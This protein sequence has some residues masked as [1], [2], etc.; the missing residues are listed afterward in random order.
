MAEPHVLF[1]LKAKRD[2]IAKHIKSLEGHLAQAK[3]DMAHVNATIRLFEVGDERLQFP[4]YVSFRS[5][6]KKGEI[7]GLCKEAMQVPASGGSADNCT[8][9]DTR[10]IAAYIIAKKGWDATDRA[11]AVSVGHSVV[12]TMGERFRRGL[13]TKAG[14]RQ[15]AVVWRLSLLT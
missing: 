14:K 4:A 8:G 7:F 12:T 5:V 10:Q 1:S 11:L 15:G 13:V 3:H 6:F 2:Q 9:L